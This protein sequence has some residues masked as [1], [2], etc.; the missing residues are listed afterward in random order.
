MAFLFF[1]HYIFKNKFTEA[2]FT[3]HII[4]QF[5][6]YSLMILLV[7]LPSCTTIS[8]NE[9]WDISIIAGRP[10]KFIPTLTPT[11]RS[12]HS[13][14]VLCRFAPSGPVTGMELYRLCLLCLASFTQHD[15]FSVHATACINS[16]SFFYC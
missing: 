13:A 16:H 11:R 14:L 10:L 12:H 4:P 5:Q 6:V 3:Y 7:Y 2:Y 8:K 9:V 15:G 1:L